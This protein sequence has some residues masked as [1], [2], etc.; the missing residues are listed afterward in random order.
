MTAETLA[1][2]KSLYEAR[3]FRAF[4][5]LLEGG[6]RLRVD[7]PD[8][9]GWSQQA[10]TVVYANEKDTFDVI[11]MDRVLSVRPAPPNGKRRKQRRRGSGDD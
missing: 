7:Q 2:L 11:P 4:E 3:P 1:K 8:Y 10:G 9:M 5:I 6:R